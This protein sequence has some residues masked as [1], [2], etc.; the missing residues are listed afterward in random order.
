[1]SISQVNS[2]DI[3]TATTINLGDDDKI[4]EEGNKESKLE[5]SFKIFIKLAYETFIPT[6]QYKEIA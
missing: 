6:K 3:T 5:I 2:E 4:S 1:M